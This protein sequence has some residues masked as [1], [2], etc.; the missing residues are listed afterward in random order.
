M[1][2]GIPLEARPSG[3]LEPGGGGVGGVG[4]AAEVPAV[5]DFGPAYILCYFRI[6]LYFKTKKNRL[7][8]WVGSLRSQ[9]RTFGKL[10]YI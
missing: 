10:V 8:G 9:K 5:A 6:L 4:L 3:E 2:S 7:A 1:T